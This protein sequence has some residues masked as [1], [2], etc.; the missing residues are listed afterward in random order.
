[1]K[2]KIYQ[3]DPY[4]DDND[5]KFM[6]LSYAQNRLGQAFPDCSIYN[7]VFDG[8]VSHHDLEDIYHLFNTAPPDGY[9]GHSLSVS[10]VVE[11]EEA[12]GDAPGFYYCDRIGFEAIEFDPAL[13][14]DATGLIRVVMVE[15]QK[16]AYI[17][18]ISSTLS[19][20]QQTV[21][22][23][24]EG[25]YPFED[26][27]CIVC[28]EEG[29]I[30]GLELNRAIWDENGHIYDIIAGPFFICDCSGENFGSLSPEMAKKYQELFRYPEA[31][32]HLNGRIE[33]VSARPNK[34]MER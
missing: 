9:K 25:F 24:I 13:T 10:D 21:G 12:Q 17:T 18:E 31:F 33:V 14:K 22:G 3:I 5:L 34:P 11:V 29:K 27:V 23:Y 7:K 6:G 8:E 15:P 26:L 28:N 16:E 32:Y 20:M 30:N 19:D 2:I 1:M 4:R